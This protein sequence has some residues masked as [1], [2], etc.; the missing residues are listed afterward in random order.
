MDS[1]MNII[2]Q[3]LDA[4]KNSQNPEMY[5]FAAA[6]VLIIVFYIVGKVLK[7]I[8][9]FLISGVLIFGY[10]AMQGKDASQILETI[11][12]TISQISGGSA[13]SAV[14][15]TVNSVEKTTG[16]S[17]VSGTMSDILSKINGSNKNSNGE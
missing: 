7:I 17:G 9:F 12:S 14:K 5:Y 8:T 4:V 16:T 1:V 15:N 13:G 2:N 10:N 6:M 3:L 11:Q